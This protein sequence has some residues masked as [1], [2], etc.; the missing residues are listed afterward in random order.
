MW[1]NQQ[2]RDIYARSGAS[3]VKNGPRRVLSV[4]F[5][6]RGLL[7]LSTRADTPNMYENLW[8]SRAGGMDVSP[9]RVRNSIPLLHSSVVIL[10]QRMRDVGRDEP[11]KMFMD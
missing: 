6:T 4:A 2:E 5:P 8:N 11:R 10:Q 7:S 9:M 3:S 1:G